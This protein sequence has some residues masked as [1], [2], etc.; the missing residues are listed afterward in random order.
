MNTIPTEILIYFFD[1]LTWKDITHVQLVNK[2]FNTVCNNIHFKRSWLSTRLGLTL[3]TDEEYFSIHM[4]KYYTLENN[5]NDINMNDYHLVHWYSL[6]DR[7]IG[8]YFL[9][10]FSELKSF[11]TINETIDFYCQNMGFYIDM[12]FW[13]FEI[14]N[15]SWRYDYKDINDICK[16]I[17]PLSITKGMFSCLWDHKY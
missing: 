10:F 11:K 9:D 7:S 4:K 3:V 17:G 16:Y 15:E 8:M 14:Y 5:V 12:E 13:M 2:R 1:K 6:N